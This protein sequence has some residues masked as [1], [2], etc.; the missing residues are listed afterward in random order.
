MTSR[1]LAYAIKYVYLNSTAIIKQSDYID[2]SIST[3]KLLNRDFVAFKSLTSK[4]K[5]N[6]HTVLAF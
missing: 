1:I 5:G 4:L 2:N 3:A 6:N